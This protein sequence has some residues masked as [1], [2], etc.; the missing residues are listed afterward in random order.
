M[1]ENKPNKTG[2]KIILLVIIL[3]V[4]VAI[5]LGLIF[6]LNSGERKEQ[7]AYEEK[8]NTYGFV[9]LYNNETAKSSENVTKSEMLK[10]VIAAILNTDDITNIAKT[11]TDN[12][13]NAVWVEYAKE[14]NIIDASYVTAEN[15]SSNANYIDAIKVISKAKKVLLEQDYGKAKDIKIKDM[16]EY[17]DSE[18]KA[19]RDLIANEIIENVNKKL[20]ATEELKK[21]EL[22]KLIVK[23][24]EKYNVKYGNIETN[25]ANLPSNKDSYPYIIAEIPK[26]VY[27]A[28]FVKDTEEKF[29]TPSQAYEDLKD[30]YETIKSNVEAYYDVLLNVN[31]ESIN[32]ESFSK[33]INELTVGLLDESEFKAYV[34]YVKT[35]KIKLEG[36]S[37]VQLPIVYYDGMEYRVRTKLEFEIKSSDTDKNLLFLDVADTKYTGKTFTCYIDVRLGKVFDNDNLYSSLKPITTMLLNDKDYGINIVES[38]GE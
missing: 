13:S 6:I 25:E 27:E 4:I 28:E 23:I 21:A 38:E 26:E 31:Y 30:K 22:N 1:K 29:Q 14:M 35:N 5:V 24:H 15:E 20:N 37:T 9:K 7:K 8:M 10:V 17:S 33:Q 16:E 34:E 32:E 11:A 19:I 18:Q 36:K 12:Y 2:K 3:I